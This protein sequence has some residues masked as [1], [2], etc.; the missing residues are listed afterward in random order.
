MDRQQAAARIAELRREIAEHDYR[1]F[2]LD[3]P[4]I[5]DAEYDRL[6]AELRALEERHPEL[7]T[8]DS[9]TRRVGGAVRGDLPELRHELPM[10]SL[11]N[12]FEDGEARAF[13]ERVAREL[14]RPPESIDW[15]VEPK[16][17][18]LALSLLYEEGRLARAATRGDGERGEEVTHTVRT[19][20]SVPL[21]LR[22]AASWLPPRLEVRG[23][24]YIPRAAF[25]ALNEQL[26][27]A[28]ERVFANPRNAAAGSIR[29]LDPRVAAARPLGFLA[30][31]LGVVEGAEPPPTQS[32]ALARLR[33]LGF[34]VS[35]EATVARG[36]EACLAHYRRLLARRDEL[37]YEIDG[38]V[39]KLDRVADQERLGFLSRAPRFAVAHKFPAREALTV[40]EGIEVQ[41]GRTGALTPVA[42]LAPVALAGVTVSHA[43]LHNFDQVARLDLRVGDTVVVRRAGDVIPE[44]VA[45]LAERRPPGAA[46][47]VPP[48]ACPVCGSAVERAAGEVVLRCSGG[49]YCPAQ[50]KEAIRHFASRRAMDIEGLG[51]RMVDE[52]V[53]SGLVATVADL[54]RLTLEDLLRMRARDGATTK[55]KV[56]TRWAEKLLAAIARSRETSLE[57]FLFALGIREV[58]EATARDLARHFGSLEAL[59][60][61]AEA[62]RPTLGTP[63]AC[64]RL[65]AVP[66]VGPVV[67]EHV[68]RFFAEPHNREV[69]AALRAA[70]VRW[71]ERPPPAATGPLA[72][73][74]FVL[75]GTFASLSREQ[76]RARLEA[77][78]ARVSDSVSARTS[79]VI[80]GANPGSK[81]ERAR[82]LGVPVLDERALEAL[83]GEASGR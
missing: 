18:G 54:Y 68:V 57:R 26:R 56:A 51:E 65:T 53:E 21:R 62:D 69:I 15:S 82:A 8:P 38:V 25:A 17:D 3:D 34:R 47:F 10:L 72:G 71:P 11:E 76:A 16:I 42:R 49:L 52:L 77:L 24:V 33:A 45:V 64:P 30:Y 2:V 43:T 81:L 29:Q 6:V 79:A 61:A 75:T 22:S 31:G 1:Y 44:V 46:P 35:P 50:R 55:G 14:G 59:I 12:V 66:G 20:R 36:P 58:G 13:F 70:G 37:P 9:P 60:A 80:A 78:G 73:Q 4:L 39:Y 7:V 27:A 67:A 28:G 83:L 63:G 41:V 48:A 19:I 40:V 32:E 74:T 5:P 23:E